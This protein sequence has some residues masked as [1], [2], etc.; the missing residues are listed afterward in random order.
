MPGEPLRG[1]PLLTL[2]SCRRIDFGASSWVE[3]VACAVECGCCGNDE[4]PPWKNAVGDPCD[5]EGTKTRTNASI[6]QLQGTGNSLAL[7]HVL[8][9]CAD[10]RHLGIVS[11]RRRAI[12]APWRTK[13]VC[14]TTHRW[15]GLMSERG[16][17]CQEDCVETLRL[18]H[19]FQGPTHPFR[20]PR[21]FSLKSPTLFA[22]SSLSSH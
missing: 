1:C 22:T 19:L 16:S 13:Q 21:T 17:A 15:F 9:T 18:L 6:C 10:V 8:L 14:R 12:E 11:R 7:Y 3:D 4:Q 2:C 5:R 20:Q